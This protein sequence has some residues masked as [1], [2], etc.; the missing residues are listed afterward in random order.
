MLRFRINYE[1]LHLVQREQLARNSPEGMDWAVLVRRHLRDLPARLD[2]FAS[3]QDKAGS[4]RLNDAL[5]A[6]IADARRDQI[7]RFPKKAGA[8]VYG[9][10]FTRK[11]ALPDQPPSDDPQGI[12]IR[13]CDPESYCA[14]L[15][16]GPRELEVQNT[17]VA[18]LLYLHP[19]RTG[20]IVWIGKVRHVYEGLTFLKRH[21]NDL[22]SFGRIDQEYQQWLEQRARAK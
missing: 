7:F 10:D 9:I 20:H 13:R 1:L 17:E 22:T 21:T 3:V 18:L 6:T 14:A 15:T 2:H 5:P 4:L 12:S 19:C 11:A 8:F 16:I